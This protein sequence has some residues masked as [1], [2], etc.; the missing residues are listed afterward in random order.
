MQLYILTP[1]NPLWPTAQF[2]KIDAIVVR[3]ANEAKAR[4]LV[5]T[6]TFYPEKSKIGRQ[7]NNPWQNRSFSKCEIY[8]G[9]QFTKEGKEEILSPAS[10]RD[11]FLQLKK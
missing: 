10:L 1:F 8:Q 5:K 7:I 4:D 11:L 3:A 6:A 2:K 9:A